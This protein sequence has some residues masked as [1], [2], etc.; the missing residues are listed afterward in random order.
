MDRK[1]AKGN[2]RMNSSES[3]INPFVLRLSNVIAWTGF[4]AMA[5]SAALTAG[6]LFVVLMHLYQLAQ[7]WGQEAEWVSCEDDFSGE[8]F[9][10]FLSE[11]CRTKYGG[12]LVYQAHGGNHIEYNGR[13]EYSALS[14]LYEENGGS[15]YSDED[16]DGSLELASYTVPPWLIC[17]LINY[18]M[19]G[20]FRFR[21]WRPI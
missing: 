3:Q 16:L 19:V 6:I 7:I 15:T 12:G 9:E 14:R 17:A 8:W 10:E 21:P 5:A 13:G 4:G 1:K 20:S 2:Y 18:L 11:R